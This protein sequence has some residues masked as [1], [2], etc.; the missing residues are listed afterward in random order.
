MASQGKK[1]IG[2]IYPAIL[3]NLTFIDD[4][5]AYSARTARIQTRIVSLYSVAGRTLFS[6]F[7][8]FTLF[9]RP[10]AASVSVVALRCASTQLSRRL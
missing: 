8:V 5:E 10:G 7:S 2:P 4:E 6:D 3:I 1:D 9:A